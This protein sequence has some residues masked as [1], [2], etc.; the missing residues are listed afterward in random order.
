MRFLKSSARS[1]M[2]GCV[3]AAASIGLSGAT[4]ASS[5]P[6]GLASMDGKA[7]EGPL[8][9]FERAWSALLASLD[10]S[11]AGAP[12][13]GPVLVFSK[14]PCPR[15][16]DGTSSDCGSATDHLC[17]GAGRTTGISFDQTTARSCR[18]GIAAP[19]GKLS[20]VCKPSAWIDHALCW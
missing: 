11:V 15:S 9:A 17:R 10:A 19:T 18:G 5:E 6:A 16:A 20:T 12:S 3:L 8:E 2:T 4:A 1:I 7:G 14:A 13:F